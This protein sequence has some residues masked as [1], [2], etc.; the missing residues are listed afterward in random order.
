LSLYSPLL[1]NLVQNI[2]RHLYSLDLW[3]GFWRSDRLWLDILLSS[4]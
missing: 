3:L 4:K 1:L 2:R